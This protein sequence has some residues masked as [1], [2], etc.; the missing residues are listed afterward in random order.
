MRTKRLARSFRSTLLAALFLLI[1]TAAAGC[2][3]TTAAH[4]IPLHAGAHMGPTACNT[5][6]VQLEPSVSKYSITHSTSPLDKLRLDVGATLHAYLLDYSRAVPT[7][8]VDHAPVA[9]CAVQVRVEQIR[10][11]T[12]RDMARFKDGSVSFRA[13]IL[14]RFDASTG[15]TEDR[16]ALDFEKAYPA[17]PNP[18]LLLVW[19]WELVA[20]QAR[21]GVALSLLMDKQIITI[22]DRLLQRADSFCK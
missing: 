13:E 6:C 4:K 15:H 22:V 18:I 2:T 1:G 11:E 10:A 9:G 20:A 12:I 16:L 8:R 14:A 3:T 19:N 7:V 21:E 17:R 5:I